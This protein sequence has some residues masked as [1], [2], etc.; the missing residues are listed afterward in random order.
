MK[1]VTSEEFQQFAELRQR[2]HR[3]SVALDFY[4]S[5]TG[6]IGKAQLQRAVCKI[7]GRPLPDQVVS[8]LPS[9]QLTCLPF[10]VTNARTG[11]DTVRV[12][13]GRNHVV[14]GMLADIAAFPWGIVMLMCMA[15]CSGG[16]HIRAVW[17]RRSGGAPAQPGIQGA[18][19]CDGEARRQHAA[20]QAAGG[21]EQSRRQLVWLPAV[22]LSVILQQG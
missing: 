14:A 8:A 22:M 2:A 10:W 20:H 5:T 3:L 12:C 9:Q 7:L 13:Q 6:R 4:H 1:Q 18:A 15:A 19:A 17:Q 21:R 16:H 11:L